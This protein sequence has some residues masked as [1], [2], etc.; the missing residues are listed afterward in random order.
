MRNRTASVTVHALVAV[1][2]LWAVVVGTADIAYAPLRR[3]LIGMVAVLLLVSVLGRLPRALGPVDDSW[4]ARGVRLLGY[5]LAATAATGIVFGIGLGGN[6]VELTRVLPYLTAV[7]TVC[8][9]AFQTVTRRGLPLEPRLLGQT[10][11]WAMGAVALWAM[12]VMLIPDAATTVGY[13]VVIGVAGVTAGVANGRPEA[14][15]ERVLVAALLGL[16]AAAETMVLAAAVM[17][18]WGP[19]G[20]SPDA[21]PGPLTPADRIEQNRIEAIDPYVGVLFLGA[22]LAF[23]LVIL[24]LAARRQRARVGFAAVGSQEALARGR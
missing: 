5:G 22:L 18:H 9:V 6:P 14:G 24:S 15:A 11:A 19:A 23:V 8:L 21:G 12:A 2:A 3:G 1:G 4:A 17:F 20:W 10:I 16:V 13:M 7:F